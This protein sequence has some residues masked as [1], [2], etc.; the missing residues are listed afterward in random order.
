MSFPMN[1]NDPNPGFKV[2]VLSKA[3]LS[4]MVHLKTKLLQDSKKPQQAIVRYQLT[5]NVHRKQ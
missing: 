2:T 1:L 4:K 3:N 5:L